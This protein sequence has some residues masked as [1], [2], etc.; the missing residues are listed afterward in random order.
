MKAGIFFTGSGPLLIL[1]TYSDLDDPQLAAK[2]KMKG[3]DR[4]IAYEVPLQRVRQIYGTKFGSVMQDV[5][6]E[7]DLRVLDY[8]GHHVFHAFSLDELKNPVFQEEIHAIV[9]TEP[10]AD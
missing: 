5:K 1:T 7:D 10:A 2:F 8:N 4:Y 9:K 6:Q 3:I